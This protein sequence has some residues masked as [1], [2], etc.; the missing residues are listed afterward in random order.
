M[1]ANDPESAIDALR[2]TYKCTCIATN[3]YL[4]MSPVFRGTKNLMKQLVAG[5]P[6]V[7]VLRLVTSRQERHFT[8]FPSNLINPLA[9]SNYDDLITLVT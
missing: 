2:Y 4:V 1:D 6:V 5:E 8:V 7:L 3:V 9:F